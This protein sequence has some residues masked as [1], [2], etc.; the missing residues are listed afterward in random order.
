MA[1]KFQKKGQIEGYDR[2]KMKPVIRN[3]G[4]NDAQVQ[5]E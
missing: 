4:C 3:R 1:Q 2:E 5:A